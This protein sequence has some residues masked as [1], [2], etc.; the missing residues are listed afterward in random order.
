MRPAGTRRARRVWAAAS[1]GALLVA[2]GACG[3]DPS[4]REPA[5]DGEASTV[6]PG[7][8][9]ST[10]AAAAA[11]LPPPDPGQALPPNDVGTL[12]RLYDPA[13][14]ALGLRLTRGALI[15]TSGDSYM[16]S[17][18]GTHLAL[19]VEPLDD[20]YTPADYV[21]GLWT[22]SALVTPDVFARW[23]GVA[24]YDI[25]QEPP[26]SVDDDKDP[27]P[28]T[29]INLTRAESAAFDWA[30][31]SLPVLLAAARTSGDFDL[32]VAKEVR[33]TPQYQ[34]ANSAASELIR[35]GPPTSSSTTSGG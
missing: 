4:A 7:A 24:S 3:S 15:D 6:V 32:V 5:P 31:G 21:E 22:V 8:S 19:Y 1:I 20:T 13:L 35:N 28:Y 34:A 12:R 14:A 16:P 17:D 27:L 33:T 29:Q 10:V 26:P 30:S 2:A 25:C 11:L 23:S 18:S 9:A